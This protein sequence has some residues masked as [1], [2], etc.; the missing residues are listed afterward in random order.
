MR[1]FHISVRRV[2]ELHIEVVILDRD[3]NQE[4]RK[5]YR[6]MPWMSNEQLEM[7]AANFATAAI[8]QKL[9]EEVEMPPLCNCDY[10]ITYSGGCLLPCPNEACATYWRKVPELAR[11]VESLIRFD[12]LDKRKGALVL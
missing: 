8:R 11:S 2:G 3:R 12:H 9:A 10:G 1:K 7:I 6:I 5:P 4:K